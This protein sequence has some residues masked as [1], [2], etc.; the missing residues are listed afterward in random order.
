MLGRIREAHRLGKVII[1]ARDQ[2]AKIKELMEQHGLC[3]STVQKWRLF[4]EQYSKEELEELCALRRPNGLPL[5]W[6][7]LPYLLTVHDK[8]ARARIQAEAADKGWPEAVMYAAIKERKI[9]NPT[10]KRAGRKRK[11]PDDPVEKVQARLLQAARL[12]GLCELASA[13]LKELKVNAK[14]A[15]ALREQVDALGNALAVVR[16][17]VSAA[18]PK[19]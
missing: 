16:R 1:D 11:E 14:A 6:G 12:V 7:Y 3:A 17:S 2:K 9:G 13:D 19:R 15:R 18:R 5:H 10:P 8:R 4:H